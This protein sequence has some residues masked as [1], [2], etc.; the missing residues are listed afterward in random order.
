MAFADMGILQKITRMLNI[1][2]GRVMKTAFFLL[3]CG[4][5][6]EV[7]KKPPSEDGKLHPM[8]NR[9]EVHTFPPL[10]GKG[11]RV[12]S[13]NPAVAADEE[14]VRKPWPHVFYSSLI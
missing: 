14:V 10:T 12:A 7:S 9:W 4:A 8:A 2:R 13:T 3:F 1:V 5:Y 11:T 6:P